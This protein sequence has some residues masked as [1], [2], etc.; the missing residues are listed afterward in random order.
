MYLARLGV[1]PEPP[2]VKGLFRIHRAQVERVAYETLWIQLGEVHGIDPVESF[3]RLATSRRGGYCY[4]LNGAL[5]VLLAQ[6]GYRVTRHVG[7]VHGPAGP[8]REEMTNHLV[9]TVGGLPHDTNPGGTWYVDAGLGDA[10]YEPLPLMAGSYRQGPILLSLEAT[11]G[12]VGDWHLIHG[13]SGSFTGMS[14]QAAETGI[15]VFEARHSWLSRSQESGFVKY[16]TVQ[17]RDV[18]GAD[19]LRGLVLKRVEIA[20]TSEQVLRTETELFDA[21]ADIFGLDVAA[22]KAVRRDLWRRLDASHQA[23]EAAGRP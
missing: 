19:V 9:L 14:W 17:R 20:Q 2:S 12:Q 7:G 22:P 21:L 5:S 1:E 23:W 6:L 3:V 8:S 13:P 16:L 10:L 4:H 15:E 18:A 11:P